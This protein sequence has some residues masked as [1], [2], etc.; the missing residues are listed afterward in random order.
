MGTL[1]RTADLDPLPISINSS[2]NSINLSV[3]D[4]DSLHQASRRVRLTGLVIS[5][6]GV[7]TLTFT[8]NTTELWRYTFPSGELTLV[9]PYNPDGWGAPTEK[10][11]QLRIGNS[12]GLTVTG[13]GNYYL[14]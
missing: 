4:T 9:L 6:T 7:G 11:E 12:G 2:D 5:V 3:G 14:L 8:S 10:G 1:R 13:V